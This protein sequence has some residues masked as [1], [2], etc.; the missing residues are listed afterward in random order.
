[1]IDLVTL[2]EARI[3]LS[4]DVMGV[5]VPAG[6]EANLV[7]GTSISIVQEL[8]GDFTVKNPLGYMYRVSGLDADALGKEVPEEALPPDLGD[9]EVT[10]E[11]VWDQIRKCYDPEIPVNIVELGLI[12]EVSIKPDNEMFAVHVEMSLTAPGCGM[13]QVLMDDVKRKLEQIPKVKTA[14]VDLTFDPPWTPERMSEEARLTTG[15]L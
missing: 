2:R 10:D 7:K 5:E 4:R 12:Y 11:V 6:V 15:L 8:G 14:T 3:E 13:G 1:M 9:K